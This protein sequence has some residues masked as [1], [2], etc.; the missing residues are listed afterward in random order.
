MKKSSLLKYLEVS[1]M[2]SVST[3]HKSIKE[4]QLE[5]EYGW[6]E[7]WG[8]GLILSGPGLNSQNIASVEGF[9]G[10][11]SS[12]RPLRCSRVDSQSWSAVPLRC[13]RVLCHER[14]SILLLMKQKMKSSLQL[15]I[16]GHREP[17]IIVS[18]WDG[19]AP[20]LIH[21][22]ASLWNYLPWCF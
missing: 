2:Q 1:T 7:G 14:G 22:A 8:G 19:G 4:V 5:A 12:I 10:K 13:C 15:F 6:V 16:T 3:H 9:Y 21:A 11:F 18:R 17:F 20:C